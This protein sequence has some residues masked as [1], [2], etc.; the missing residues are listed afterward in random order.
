MAYGEAERTAP[1]VKKPNNLTL[2]NRRKLTISGVEDV[3]RFDETEVSMRTGEGSLV[4][5]GE[6]LRISRLSVEGGDVNITG[7]ITELRYEEPQPE[8]GFWARLFG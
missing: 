1:A 7:L 6:D 4:V 3:E 5:R 8:R 2:E